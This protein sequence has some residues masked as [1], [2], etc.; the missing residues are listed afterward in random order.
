MYDRKECALTIETVALA[1]VL[2]FKIV[3]IAFSAEESK[4]ETTATDGVVIKSCVG[5]CASRRRPFLHP[6]DARQ[7]W[8]M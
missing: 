7:G 5:G 4:A 6:L 3:G 8:N 2:R 1:L